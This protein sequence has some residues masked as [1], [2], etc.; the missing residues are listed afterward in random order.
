LS[1][2][3]LFPGSSGVQLIEERAGT[4]NAAI[5]AAAAGGGQQI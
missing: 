3:G 4:D 2:D 1:H 5:A